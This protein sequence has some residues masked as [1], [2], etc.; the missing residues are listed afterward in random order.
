MASNQKVVDPKIEALLEL[1]RRG[2]LPSDL[3]EQLDFARRQGMAPPLKGE[4]NANALQKAAEIFDTLRKA[5]EAVGAT[6]TGFGGSIVGNIPGTEGR[7]LRGYADTLRANL[8]FD[9]L[10]KMRQNSPTGG[11]LGVI[12]DK[13]STLLASTVASLDLGQKPDVVKANLDKIAQHYGQWLTDLGYNEDQIKQV[14]AGTYHAPSTSSSDG[15]SGGN[16]PAGGSPPVAPNGSAPSI[17]PVSGGGG[18]ME[19]SKGGQREFSTDKDTAYASDVQRLLSDPKTTRADFDALSRQYGYPAMGKDLDEALKTRAERP[20]VRINVKTPISGK[21]DVSPFAEMAS[22]APGAFLANAANAGAMGTLPKVGAAVSALGGRL[23]SDNRPIGDIYAENL[24]ENNIKMGLLNQAHPTAALGGEVAGLIGGSQMLGSGLRAAGAASPALGALGSRLSPMAAQAGQDALQGAMLG[25]GSSNDLESAGK[26][27]L[28]G[29]A[30]GGLGSYGG[31]VAAKGFGTALA[32]VASPAVQKM[33]AS[34]ITMTPGQILGQSGRVGRAVKGAEDWLAGLPGIGGSI[35]EARRVGTEDLNRAALD[36]VLA[37]IG[38]KA[39]GIGHEGVASAQ[40]KVNQARIDAISRMQLVP[41]QQLG[42]DLQ[43]V[44]SDVGALSKAHQEHF[45]SIM[46]RDVQP[47]IRNQQALSG[48]EISKLDQGLNARIANLR[49]PGS[50]PQDRELADTLVGVRDA[51]F[52]NAGRTSPD[53]IEAYNAYKRSYAL[54]SRVE[55]A[56]SKAKD[57]VFTAQQFK[58][59][60]GRKGYGTSRK[61]L[62]TGSAPFQELSNAASTVLPSSIPDS[63]TAGRNVVA[64]MLGMHG[65]G[66]ALGGAGGYAEGGQAGALGGALAG[67]ALGSAAFSRPVLRGVQNALVAQRPKAVSTLGDVIRNRSRIVGTA[68]GTPLAFNE[69]QD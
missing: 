35:K 49:G 22:S 14:Q 42:A 34:G 16:P 37:P 56:A 28:A 69:V 68:V 2:E 25:A 3:K 53:A 18:Q 62:A 46:A 43:A 40:A 21:E 20:N 1:E 8:A 59:A 10:A 12:S 39:E 27:A 66:A 36:E 17:P 5:K 23:G 50:S 54:L 13:E 47:Y 7:S 11:A 19:L 29:A 38:Q 55:D 26:N 52:D 67:A 48:E 61:N 45:D 51:I 15:N 24:A 64:G 63:G 4:P 30:L 6:T 57:G 60:V 31:Q 65:V 44:K 33:A 41:D 9:E 32:P 58:T